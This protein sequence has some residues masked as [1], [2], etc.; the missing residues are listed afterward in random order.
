VPQFT[1]YLFAPWKLFALLGIKPGA[2]G[3]G[4]SGN[5]ALCA[6]QDVGGGQMINTCHVLGYDMPSFVFFASLLIL[7]LFVLASLSLLY[8]CNRLAFSLG[9]LTTALGKVPAPTGK[10]LTA[11]ELA[12]IKTLMEKEAV[13]AHPWALFEETLLVSNEGDEIYSTQAVESVFSK[14]A[15]IEENVHSAFFSAIPGV[16]TGVGLLMTFV[17]ILD[18]LSHVSV[19]ANMDVKGIGGLINGLSGKFVSSIV[20]VTC[21]VLFVFVERIAYS[22]PHD[23]Y[24]KLISRITSRFRRRTTEHLL[25]HIQAQ[26]V[27]QAQTLQQL[28]RER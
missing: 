1:D 6:F 25:F 27:S 16:L 8:Q 15:L 11:A 24:R 20:A 23:A 19:A 26:L 28:Q 9:R 2:S 13:A 4:G 14:A 7:S 21:A 22:A 18:G 10:S 17:A 5:G 3:G 12:R